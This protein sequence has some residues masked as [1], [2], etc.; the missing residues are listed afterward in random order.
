V[1]SGGLHG[2]AL[3]GAIKPSERNTLNK[4]LTAL[5]FIWV[6]IFLAGIIFND[7]LP[8]NE[9]GF[10]IYIGCMLVVFTTYYLIAQLRN[11]KNLK[12]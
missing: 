8:Y 7:G 5:E 4:I 3:F 11:T 12:P 1:A 10:G 2:Y 9:Y 6:L